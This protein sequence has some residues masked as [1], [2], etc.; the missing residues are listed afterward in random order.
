MSQVLERLSILHSPQG[1]SASAYRTA[2]GVGTDAMSEAM[3]GGV[4]LTGMAGNAWTRLR[5]LSSGRIDVDLNRALT[6]K[7]FARELLEGV[8]AAD[9]REWQQLAIRKAQRAGAP[10]AARSL[11]QS[12]QP[13][14]RKR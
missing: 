3:R 2:S 11:G 12:I 14:A 6:D 1:D 5:N 10:A 9:V 8:T 4:T 13:E 7:R